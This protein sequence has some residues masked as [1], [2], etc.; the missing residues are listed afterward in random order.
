M[1]LLLMAGLGPALFVV[2]LMIDSVTR[3]GYD[4]LHHFGSELANGDRG[5]LMILD[6]VVAG[7]LTICFAFGLRRALGIVAA[8]VLVGLGLVVAG[9]FVADPKPGYGGPVPANPTLHSQIHDANLFPTWIAMTAAMVMFAVHFAREKQR[10]WASYSLISAVAAMGTL[11]VA[12]ALYGA[13][14]QTGSYHGLWQ[15][16]SITIGFG[17]FSVLAVR[18]LSGSGRLRVSRRRAPRSVRA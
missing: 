9:V 16:I 5:W 15:R 10:L 18:M 4:L 17:Y 12:V 6:F 11:L 3:P 14:V 13:D 7:V 8:P 2:V 1:T